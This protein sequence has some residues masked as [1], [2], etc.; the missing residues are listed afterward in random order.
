ML[1]ENL[2]YL[3]LAVVV[4][5]ALYL[6]IK[7]ANI[8]RAESDEV[9]NS[10]SPAN[11]TAATPPTIGGSKPRADKIRILFLAANP[12]ET[13]PLSLGEEVR[14]IDDALLRAAHRDLFEMEQQWAVRLSDLQAHLLRYS[15]DIVHFSG[16]GTTAN[17]IILE[18]EHGESQ[19]VSAALLSQ[20][21]SLLRDNIRCV[22][23][24]ACYSARQADAIG[25][26]IDCVVGM[27][28]AM[29]DSAAIAFS[30]SFYQAL[31]YGRSVGTAFALGANQIDL[32]S[33]PQSHT[34]HLIDKRAV[35]DQTC[36][37]EP[38]RAH[39]APDD[40]G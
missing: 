25:D 2:A 39:H 37:V 13:P 23:L 6:A 21:F 40:A 36:F 27:N 1:A 32:A 17:E 35:A 5:S 28:D 38:S 3:L 11:E 18:N 26:S 22:V 10:A 19:P 16:H 15:P 4:I 20:L 7:L 12:K 24:S 34:P 14:A 30:A 31:A 29:S 33:L 8:W 9:P